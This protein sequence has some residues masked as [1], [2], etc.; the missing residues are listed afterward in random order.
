MLKN[1]FAVCLITMFSVAGMAAEMAPYVPAERPVPHREFVA[2]DEAKSPFDDLRTEPTAEV[3]TR[4]LGGMWKFSGVEKSAVPFRAEDDLRSGFLNGD[5]N[6]SKWGEIKVPLNWFRDARW[7]YSKCYNPKE[8]FTRGYYRRSFHLSP[9]DLAGRR[10]RLNFDTI[11]YEGRVFINGKEAGTARGEFTPSSF[12]ITGLVKAGENRIAIRVLSDFVPLGQSE[13]KTSHVY[14]ARWWYENIKGGIWQPVTLTLEPEIRFDRIA[15]ASRFAEKKLEI[16]CRI[17]NN[18]SSVR[19]LRLRGAVGD[20]AREN[21]GRVEASADFG[22][23]RLNPGVNEFRLELKL[24]HP[25]AWKP[26]A[27]ELSFLT[28]ALDDGNAEKAIRHTRFGFREFTVRGNRFYLNGQPIY[29]FGENISSTDFGGY[30]RTPEQEEAMIR[31][32]LE[33]RL[34]AGVVI[35]RTAHMPA[36]RAL[37]RLADESGMMIY[38][39]WGYSFTLMNMEEEKFERNNLNELA[40]FIERDFN[41]PSVVM[42]SLGNEVQHGTRPEAYRQLTRQIER[43]RALDFQKRPVVP[44]SG[45]A[46]IAHYGSGKFD[47]D[48]LDLHTYHGIVDNPWTHY[49]AE[50]DSHQK[51]IAEV[52]GKTTPLITWESVGYTWGDWKDAKFHAGDL[53]AYLKYARTDFTWGL[54]CGIG[55]AAATGLAAVVDPKRGLRDVMDRQAGRFFDLYRQDPAFQGFAPWGMPPDLPQRTRW[56]QPVYAALRSAPNGLPPRNLFF[57]E[58]YGWEL[59]L[60][61]DSAETLKNPRIRLGLIGEGLPEETLATTDFPS[62][63]AGKQAVRTIELALP[64]K[65]ASAP[66]PAQLRLT[67]F[68]ADGREVGRNYAN[69]T[70][71]DPRL[72]TDAVKTAVRIGLFETGEYARVAEFLNAVRIPFLTLKPGASLNTFDT[73]LIA[74]GSSPAAFKQPETA[75]RNHVENGACLV[76]LEQNPGPLP[77]YPRFLCTRDPNSLAD[78]VLPQHPIFRGMSQEQFDLWSSAENGD[79]LSAMISPITEN[80]LAAKPPFLV[81]KTVGMAIMEAAVGKGRLIVSQLNACANWK[82]ESAATRY[83]RNLLE[84]AGNRPLRAGARPLAEIAPPEYQAETEDLAPIDLAPWANRSF[85]DEKDND[86]KGGWTDQGTNDFRVM[87]TGT[88]K[89]A[90]I[91]FTIID[92]A[93]NQDKGCLMVRGSARPSLPS[94]IRDIRISGKY[95]RLFFLHTSAWS[96][97][98]FCGAYRIDYADGTSVDIPLNGDRNIGDWWQVKQLPEAK[99]GFARKNAAGA[100]IGFFV[101]EWNNP[102]PE[103]TIERMD[104]LSAIQEDAGGVDWVNPNAAIPIL[105]AVTG[106]KSRGIPL[107]IY[108]GKSEK[109]TWWGMA[110]QGGKKPE[111]R[112]V[113][114]GKDAPTPYAMRFK[115]PAG[116]HNGVPVVSTKYDPSGIP[117]TPRAVVFRVKAEGP[118]VIDLVFPSKDWKSCFTATV[119]LN[120]PGRWITVRLPVKAFR[121]T[122]A[123]FPLRE[124]RPEFYLYNG[125]NQQK[126]YPRS[127][128]TFEL[129][130]LEIE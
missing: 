49:K 20:A 38:D 97:M 39:E 40:R 110:W 46:C 74:P 9:E 114:T 101:M 22:T 52:Y 11:G 45:V 35:L 70:L 92:P 65:N 128:I 28:L 84:Y 10:V 103:K 47:A 8:P 30:D 124:G 79:V 48:V 12:D 113:K 26:G 15:I 2:V 13:F 104:F 94:A 1:S 87:P 85:S 89:A 14:G 107:E 123:P 23:K 100:E 17:E 41:A 125:F 120:E 60:T 33:K 34:K 66:V 24:D 112:A 118:G 31:D 83:L 56:N 75:I 116:E 102:H 115:L 58:K 68:D 64:Q 7:S 108:S 98:G 76:I 57:G 111:I 16:A 63:E 80:V 62:L 51:S 43:V 25:R 21:A 130:G 50:M 73:L 81:K 71:E 78:L 99:W 126:S 72:R 77:V 6:D 117:G 122:G 27:P 91:P 121:Y 96:N 95:S 54:P 5:F 18:T 106:E 109:H 105:A 119:E 82:T 42:W 59:F 93:K 53:D 90:G 4:D 19:E 37:I 88:I 61:N 44:F 3:I 32:I 127:E 36:V 69:I 67:V 86:G 55:Y 29:L 129:T